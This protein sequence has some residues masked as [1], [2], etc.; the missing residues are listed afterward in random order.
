MS[1]YTSGKSSKTCPGTNFWGMGN[2]VASAKKGFLVDVKAEYGRLKGNIKEEDEPM[3]AEE[4]AAID[5]LVD[6]VNELEAAAKRVP[7]PK[8]FVAEF[9][10]EELGGVISE[11]TF[12]AEG[13]R[14]LAV[15][16]RVK[17]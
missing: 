3:T 17:K 14:T 9:G 11:P 4:K 8:W 16:L 7:A 10:S 15:G 13:W 1:D 6:R 5:K 2:T 12:T